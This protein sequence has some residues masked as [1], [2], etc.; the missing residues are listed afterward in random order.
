[1]IGIYKI[2]NKVNGKI[3]VGQSVNIE[4]RWKNHRYE[5]MNNTHY[6]EHLQRSWNKYGSDNFVFSI[7]EECEKEN[8]DD[9][10]IYWI[11]YL[12][13]CE[14]QYGYNSQLGGTGD[15]I[16]KPVLQFDLT[17]NFIKEWKSAREASISLEIP[18]KGIYW[19]CV[20]KYKNSSLYIWIYKDDYVDENSLKWYL[21]NQKQKNIN[22]YDLYGR[23]IKTWKNHAEI[24]EYFGYS[25][26]GCTRHKNLSSHGYIWLYTNDELE[27]TEEYCYYVRNSLKIVNNKPF[28]QVDE[29]CNIVEK[30]NC[31]REVKSNGF[32]AKSVGECLRNL[33]NSTKGFV[34]IY[35]DKY[36]TL[37]EDKCVKLLSEKESPKY[38]EVI[39][40]DFNNNIINIYHSLNDLP[41]EFHKQNVSQCCRGLTKQ[42]KGY[43]WKYGKET[44][45]P[46]SRQVEMYNKDTGELLYTFHSV[47][48]ANN[49]TNISPQTIIAACM[50]KIKTSGNYIWK[51]SDD[52]SFIVD[53]EYIE[54]LKIH[55]GCKPLY[56]YDFNNQLVKTYNSLKSAVEDGYTASSIR[57]C[58]KNEIDTYKGFVWRYGEVS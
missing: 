48:E 19:C 55:G 25:V 41:K 54:K 21:Q 3:Y 49:K 5:L 47:T 17:G 56:V 16:Y 11:D 44:D 37:T 18:Q 50:R 30:Y 33:R 38:C 23:Y 36:E 26:N 20:K 2:E 24:N 39:Q 1:M 22:Q 8:L 45:N 58:C 14:Y 10:E 31:L 53:R 57:K 52:D 51:Y 7:I 43:V 32:N 34:W 4:T 13:S 27:L 9:R 28:Y 15:L 29:H 46:L 6:N 42:Y 40:C 12:H 35:Q